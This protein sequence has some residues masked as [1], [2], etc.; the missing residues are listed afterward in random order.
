MEKTPSDPE[1][2]ENSRKRTQGNEKRKGEDSSYPK[3][4]EV[5]LSETAQQGFPDPEEVDNPMITPQDFDIRQ[6]GTSL[7]APTQRLLDTTNRS[8]LAF[9]SSSDHSGAPFQEVPWKITREVEGQRGQDRV[10]QEAEDSGN[11]YL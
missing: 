8:L 5:L 2:W 9:S 4:I 11:E 10:S 3:G 1:L 7:G 6:S